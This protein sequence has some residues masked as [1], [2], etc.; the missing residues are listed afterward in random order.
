MKKINSDIFDGLECYVFTLGVLAMVIVPLVF[1]VLNTNAK[2]IRS[3][4]YPQTM[5]VTYI[6]EY[7]DYVQIETAT[8]YTYGFWG[9]EDYEVDDVVAVTMNDN[10][11]END[12]TDDKIVEVR[13]SGFTESEVK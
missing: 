5:V 12:I 11:T 4:E 6:N 2:P 10:A 1:N 9:I 7:T 3:K 13:F 8:G